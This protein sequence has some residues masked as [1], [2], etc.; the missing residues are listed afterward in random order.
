M[1]GDIDQALKD[2]RSARNE[3]H[4]AEAVRHYE[5]AA[6]LARSANES[7]LLAH[8]LRHIADIVREHGDAERALEAAREAVLLYRA[9]DGSVLELANALRVNALALQATG[10][11]DAATPLWVEARRLYDEVDVRAGV[12]ECD[13][14]LKDQRS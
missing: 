7:R 2:G 11:P 13:R 1:H 8:A 3:G 4:P 12:D 5:R 10:R 9:N 6:A 14:Y